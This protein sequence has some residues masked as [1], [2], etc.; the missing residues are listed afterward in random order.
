MPQTTKNS[1]YPAIEPYSSGF[2][3]VDDI[4]SL[5]WE[6]CGNPHGVPILFLHGGPGSGSSPFHRRFYDPEHYRI[7][8]FD[9][10]GAGR[11]SPHASLEKNT[12]KELVSDIEKIRTHLRIEKWHVC[13]GSWGSTLALSYAVEHTQRVKS[14]I[15]RGVFLLEQPEVDWFLYGIKAVFP[16]VWDKFSGYV[17]HAPDLLNAYYSLLTSNDED[18]ALKAGVNWSG[19]E[20]ACAS[21]LPKPATISHVDIDRASLAIARMEAHYF[22]YEVIA[23]ENSILKQVHKLQKIPAVIIQGRYDMICPIQTAYK[24]HKAW[25]E[26]DYIVVPNGGHTANEF[27]IQKRIIEATNNMKAIL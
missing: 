10:R 21:L 6:Q 24:L 26:A 8:I 20:A 13:G 17:D 19:Y 11:S 18:I 4:H 7:I 3:E 25:P 22:K 15:V 9:Q 5:Y 16:D 14:L 27:P 2:I 1:L 12:R 23:P